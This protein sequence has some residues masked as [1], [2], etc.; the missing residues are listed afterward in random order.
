ML[1][2]LFQIIIYPLYAGL[3]TI[4]SFFFDFFVFRRRPDKRKRKLFPLSVFSV[5]FRQGL[6]KAM[7]FTLDEKGVSV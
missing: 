1:N 6:P 5:S 7:H 2:I 4:F 3:E